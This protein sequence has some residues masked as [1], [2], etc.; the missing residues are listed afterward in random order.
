MNVRLHKRA[1]KDLKKLTKKDN[2]RFED[3]VVLLSFNYTNPMSIL[4]LAAS[5]VSP[6]QVVGLCHSIQGASHHLA[7]R[8]EVP[9]EEME[10]D[11]AGINHMAWFTKLKHKGVDL[12]PRIMEKARQDLAGNPSNEE[13]KWD[14]V[15][16]DMMLHFGA[17][18]TESSGHLSEYL[19]YY[20]KRKDLLEKYMGPKYEGQSSFYAD[21]WPGW[22]KKADEDRLAMVNGE[23]SIDWKRSWEYASNIIEAREK[24]SPYCIYGNVSNNSGVGGGELITNLPSDSCVEVACMVDR[25]GIQPIRF[26]NMPPQ[27]AHMCASNIAMHDLAATACMERSHEAAVYALLLDPL[28]AAVCSPAEIKAM[29]YEM[30]EAEKDFLPGFK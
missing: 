29:Y 8:A 30:Y 28:S 19:P 11:C 22:R 1:R 18:M 14:L 20:R 12:Y 26:G 17:Y 21:E 25:N 15:R 3:R 10:W 23:Q 6:V 4:C 2:K 7:K 16:K 13:D 27:M 5:R 9:F 24:N